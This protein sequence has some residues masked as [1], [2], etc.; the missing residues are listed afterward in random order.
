MVGPPASLMT[1]GPAEDKAQPC[2]HM[3]RWPHMHTHK[4]ILCTY[5]HTWSSTVSQSSPEHLTP[6]SSKCKQLWIPHPPL[7][8]CPTLVSV[9]DIVQPDRL[10]GAISSKVGI[11][12]GNWG[13]REAQLTAYHLG[14]LYSPEVITHR[15]PGVVVV[16]L[17]PPLQRGG[18]SHQPDLHIDHWSGCVWKKKKKTGR[19]RMV[20]EV[21]KRSREKYK[22]KGKG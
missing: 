16:H 11:G 1:W 20:K 10:I 22:E 17:H 3:H 6:A 19:S 18:A 5:T 4:H 14:I 7:R 2:H 8:H 13:P 12:K 15:P 21:G 9:L